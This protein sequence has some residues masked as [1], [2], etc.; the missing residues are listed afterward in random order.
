[1]SSVIKY[2]CAIIGSGFV[3][4]NLQ[5]VIVGKGIRAYVF[6]KEGKRATGVDPY[7]PTSVADLVC[8]AEQDQNFSGVFFVCVPSPMLI[9]TGECDTR[10]VESVLREL[11]DV[12]GKRIAVVKS[13]VPPGSC[14]RWSDMFDRLSVCHSPE[15]LREAT[16]YY[17]TLTQ[18]GRIVIGGDS[19]ATAQV[20]KVFEQ[21]FPDVPIIETTSSISEMVKYFINIQL[22]ARLVLSCEFHE[23]CQKLNGLGTVINYD[24]VVRI[25][26]LDSRLGGSHM[27]VPGP[28]GK[29]GAMGSCFPKDLSA[30][31]F[32]SEKLGIIP[33]LMRA[34]KMKNLALI[35]PEERDWEVMHGRAVST[36][37]G[38]GYKPLAPQGWRI[39]VHPMVHRMVV[40]PLTG[41][42]FGN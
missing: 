8:H 22:C 18:S 11:N 26:S 7:R 15:F 13:T 1:M 36:K 34:I 29:I 19:N 2:S 20:R 12:P 35:L 16:A 28:N 6:D 39:P 30:M 25:A 37:N 42:L 5:Q 9:E 17:D 41:W 3:G 23:L 32:A 10:I 24:E 38:N 14:E 31:V 4:G 40:K 21:A 33:S 27:S